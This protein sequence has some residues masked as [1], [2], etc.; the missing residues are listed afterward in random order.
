M[1]F[2]WMLTV[3]LDIM[4]II[5]AVDAA[6][7]KAERDEHDERRPKTIRIQQVVAEEDRCKNEGVLK[8]LQRSNQLNVLYHQT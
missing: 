7:N 1:A 5:E 2:L 4:Q 8:P 6:G 3:C